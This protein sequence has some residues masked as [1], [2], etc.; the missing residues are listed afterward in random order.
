[1]VTDYPVNYLCPQGAQ[2]TVPSQAESSQTSPERCSEAASFQSLWPR[3]SMA[4]TP[5]RPL[6]LL[7]RWACAVGTQHTTKCCWQ[8]ASM[9][10]A[11]GAF[12]HILV[13]GLLY[14]MNTAFLCPLL[15]Y[16]IRICSTI[17]GSA[18]WTTLY[19]FFSDCLPY[20]PLYSVPRTM[21]GI[22]RCS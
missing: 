5:A 7:L 13:I 16:S 22:V 15:G 20:S 2:S 17:V 21:F 19:L 9:Q 1:M 6:P 10:N 4:S 12:Q 11:K 3:L 14:F 8:P 18:E